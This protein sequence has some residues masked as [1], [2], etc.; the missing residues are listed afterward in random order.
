MEKFETNWLNCTVE[1]LQETEMT[2]DF[3]FQEW[4]VF[5]QEQINK[6]KKTIDWLQ[7]IVNSPLMRIN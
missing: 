2:I 1:E 3:A 4:V 7:E 5:T 6:I